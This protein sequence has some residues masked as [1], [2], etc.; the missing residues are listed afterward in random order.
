MNKNR[1]IRQADAAEAHPGKRMIQDRLSLGPYETV[2]DVADITRMGRTSVRQWLDQM[3]ADGQVGHVSHALLG[4]NSTARYCLV[5]D[6]VRALEDT[7]A[8]S[9]PPLLSRRGVTNKGLSALRKRLDILA[10]VY[11]LVA[12]I[13]SCYPRG[14]VAL[15]VYTGGPLDAAV[16]LP[17]PPRGGKDSFWVGIIVRRPGLYQKSFELRLWEYKDPKVAPEERP[18]RP[19]A[20]LVLSPDAMSNRRVARLVE[21]NYSGL[22]WIAP[23]T[24]LESAETR[25]WRQRTVYDR[26]T[27]SLYE[28]LEALTGEDGQAPHAP[29]VEP[30]ERAALALA[31]PPPGP[32]L[33]QADKCVMFALADWPLEDAAGVAIF[34]SV[35][36]AQVLTSMTTLRRYSLARTVETRPVPRFAL[37]D[38]GLKMLSAAAREKYSQVRRRWS[39]ERNAGGLFVGTR[40]RTRW[41][42]RSHTL[43]GYEV[44]RRFAKVASELAYV[45]DYAV[46]PEHQGRQSFL[47]QGFRYPFRILPD[48]TVLLHNKEDVDGRPAGG[49]TREWREAILVEIEQGA[50]SVEDMKDRL[51]S[52]ARYYGTERPNTDYGTLPYVAVVLKDAGMEERFLAAQ[53]AAQLTGLPIITT[54]PDRLG[55]DPLGPFGTVWRSPRNLDVVIPYWHWQRVKE[56]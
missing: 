2:D 38:E 56:E 51:S 37:T 40:L 44:A 11:R 34:A 53:R 6:G 30:Y 25:V 42:E 48:V 14:A 3:V 47:V 45:L 20:L 12:T 1:H 16:E 22:A 32:A 13:A 10:C 43:M 33:T 39:S 21:R 27:W 18:S 5:R 8:D 23:V 36:E 26:E 28:I 9:I 4:R 46:L 29:D 54:T 17:G 35:G 7:L 52:Y 24:D 55:Q 19:T 49:T 31:T 15:T 50:A 41:R